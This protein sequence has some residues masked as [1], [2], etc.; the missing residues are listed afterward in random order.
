M[1]GLQCRQNN[2]KDVSIESA[3]DGNYTLSVIVQ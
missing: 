3:I 2:G 1:T